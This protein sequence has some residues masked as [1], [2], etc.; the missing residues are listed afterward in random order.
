M[1]RRTALALFAA[2]AALA[3]AAV[4]VAVR[5]DP[6]ELVPAVDPTNLDVLARDVPGLGAAAGWLNGPPLGPDDLAGKVVVYDFWTY[7]CVNCVRTLPHLRAWWDRYR[8]DGLVIVGVHSPEF[9]FERDHA[10]VERA[11]RDLRVEW[12]VALDDDMHIW[13][14]FANRY[15][16]AKYVADRDG[17]LR[18]VHFGEGRYDETEDVL[19]A[20]L[21]VDEGSPRAGDPDEEPPPS[22]EVTRET[23]LGSLRGRTAS[24]E[25][26]RDNGDRTF[27][28]PDAALDPGEWAL[29]GEWRVTDEYIEALAPGAVLELRYIAGEVN[30]V[31]DTAG[32]P[33]D[34]GVRVDDEP[35]PP[36]G[37]STVTVDHADLYGLVSDGPPGPHTLRLVAAQPGLRAYAFTFGAG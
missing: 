27:T 1:T 4:L 25:G 22:D 18:Y 28:A 13:R 24:P 15:W 16:P 21:G 10:N 37:E 2:V 12:P 34:V 19:R 5:Y 8:E 14:A 9:E 30:L 7:S 36:G 29:V 31:L 17:Q 23:Y 35:K 20:L 33:V 32:G 3:V 11:V 6:E 26:T